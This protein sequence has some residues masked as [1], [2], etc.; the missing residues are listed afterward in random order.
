MLEARWLS[1]TILVISIHSHPIGLAENGGGFKY[2]RPGGPRRQRG[3]W[4]RPRQKKNEFSHEQP[5]DPHDPLGRLGPPG[6][7]YGS[8]GCPRQRTSGTFPVGR[9]EFKKSFL[10]PH[11]QFVVIL[12]TGSQPYGMTVIF[13]DPPGSHWPQCSQSSQMLPPDGGR[14]R[15]SPEMPPISFCGVPLWHVAVPPWHT[16]AGDAPS[17]AG[18]AGGFNLPR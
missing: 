18:K 16:G 6:R 15:I 2:R 10:R 17:K 7:L 3:Q 5:S 4:G 11:A 9:T 1:M 8:D 13:I 14:I 12:G